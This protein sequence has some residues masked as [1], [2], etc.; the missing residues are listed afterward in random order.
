MPA[1]PLSVFSL[2]TKL[3]PLASILVDPASDGTPRGRV[4]TDV[5]VINKGQVVHDCL[6]TVEKDSLE[7]FYQANKTTAITLTF[8][9]KNYELYFEGIPYATPLNGAG[10]Y[11]HVVSTMSGKML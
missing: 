3:Q 6:A 11:W 5:E 8:A 9:G 10:E 7:A 1:Y 2:K 4:M